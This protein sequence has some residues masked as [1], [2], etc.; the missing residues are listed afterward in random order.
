MFS[1]LNRSVIYYI[2]FTTSL[3]HR[4]ENNKAIHLRS[5]ALST[6]VLGSR[7]N[8]LLIPQFLLFSNL[9]ICRQWLRHLSGEVGKRNQ[10]AYASC[11]KNLLCP[12]LILSMKQEERFD[13]WAESGIRLEKDKMCQRVEG[14]FRKNKK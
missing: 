8:I 12:H 13:G 2:N 3:L 4:V 5:Y 10:G 7:T 11:N 14:H 6:I 1:L 9:G